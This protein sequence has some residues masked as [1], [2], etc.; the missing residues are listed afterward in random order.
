MKKLI[1]SIILLTL[2]SC[3]DSQSN[4]CA[5]S[6][7]TEYPEISLTAPPDTGQIWNVPVFFHVLY[8]L[9]RE[10]IHDSL[11][12]GI[13][14]TLNSDFLNLNTDLNNVPDEFKSFI[15]N[16]KVNFMIA[17]QLPNGEKT[18][19]IFRKKTNVQEFKYKHRNMFDESAIIDSKKFLNVY[20]CNVNTNAFTPTENNTHHN[21]VVINYRKVFRGSRTLTHEAGHWFDLL[22]IFEGGCANND[23]I[24]DTPPQKKNRHTCPGYPKKDCGESTMFMNYMDY[25]LC[26]CFFTAEQVKRMRNYI[27]KYKNF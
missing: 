7:R 22:H 9:D 8:N 27:I 21:G 17:T 26:R 13:M 15:G 18:T 16:P 12:L 20:V 25:S 23:L 14:E 2:T 24:S 11:I 1:S 19:G 4:D 5:T 3:G 10:N 6:K